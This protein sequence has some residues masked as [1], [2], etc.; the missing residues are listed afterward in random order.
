MS[1]NGKFHTTTLTQIC[2]YLWEVGTEIHSRPE[3]KY[4]FHFAD[5]LR[6]SKSLKISPRISPAPQPIQIAHAAHH[7]AFEKL[8]LIV[9]R[10]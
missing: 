5:F 10:R 6:T 8:L 3:L 1:L 9:L 7:T 4:G 2:N